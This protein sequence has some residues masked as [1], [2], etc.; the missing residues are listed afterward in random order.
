MAVYVQSNEP[1]VAGLASGRSEGGIESQW[2]SCR[3]V[4]VYYNEGERR[5]LSVKSRRG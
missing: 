1:R 2:L 4:H 3:A 5:G